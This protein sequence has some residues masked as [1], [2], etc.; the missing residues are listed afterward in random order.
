[1]VLQEVAEVTKEK[2]CFFRQEG[3]FKVQ[4]RDKGGE[5][6]ENIGDCVVFQSATEVRQKYYKVRQGGRV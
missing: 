5:S 2:K 6:L 3:G 4:Q 1:M